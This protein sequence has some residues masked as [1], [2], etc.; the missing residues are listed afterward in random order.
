MRRGAF[1]DA[2]R[3]KRRTTRQERNKKAAKRGTRRRPLSLTRAKLGGWGPPLS[4]AF[5]FDKG[6]GWGEG[7]PLSL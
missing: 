6:C 5:R 2:A 7:L 3:R 1:E 4:G